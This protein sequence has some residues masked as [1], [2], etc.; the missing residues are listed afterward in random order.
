[1]KMNSDDKFYVVIIFKISALLYSSDLK[2]LIGVDLSDW[3]AEFTFSLLSDPPQLSNSS[4]AILCR[5]SFEFALARLG[6]RQVMRT[7]L[8]LCVLR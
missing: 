3:T 6:A 5:A 2:T 4:R 7:L 8:F 1:M